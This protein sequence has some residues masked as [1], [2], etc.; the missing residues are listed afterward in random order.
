MTEH[1]E[2]GDSI[3]GKRLVFEGRKVG[4]AELISKSGKHRGQRVILN[5]GICWIENPIN[6][7]MR[8]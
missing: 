5:D 7:S 8:S 4:K 1:I 6:L 3:R 2:I